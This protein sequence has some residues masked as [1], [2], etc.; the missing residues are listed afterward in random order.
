MNPLS[1]LQ[2]IGISAL[3]ALLS[4]G[5]GY[6]YGLYSAHADC[7]KD[8]KV[9]NAEVKVELARD[10]VQT[11]KRGAKRAVA[12]VN[13]AATLAPL[14]KK[15][16]DDAKTLSAALLN[17]RLDDNGVRDLTALIRASNAAIGMHPP[18]AA[19]A[20]T[21]VGVTR[22]AGALGDANDPSI[23]RDI[24]RPQLPDRVG[25]RVGQQGAEK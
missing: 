13:D 11:A 1:I 22:G 14:K 12:R 20:G 19:A 7:E 18:A 3:S 15:V 10:E 9:A 17:C 21:R 25:Q 16:I 8:K 24:E 4:A 6:A 23:R 2:W 5:G